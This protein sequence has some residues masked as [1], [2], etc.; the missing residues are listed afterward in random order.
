MGGMHFTDSE[1]KHLKKLCRIDCSEEEEGDI[2]SSLQKTIAY[3]KQLD[4]IDTEGVQPCRFVLRNMLKGL[5]REDTPHDLLSRET[6]LSN[7]PDQVGGMVRV[8]PI[9]SNE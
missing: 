7:A 9:L 5:L 3:V 6:F 1:L 2:L 4:K 8:P